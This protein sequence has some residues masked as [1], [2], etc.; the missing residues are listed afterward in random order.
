MNIENVV[1]VFDN[2][3]LK[4]DCPSEFTDGKA[5]ALLGA[6]DGPFERFPDA[7]RKRAPGPAARRRCGARVRAL[8][9][10]I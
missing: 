1:E 5:P 8:S 3:F 4:N 10:S 2:L 9:R 6:G 7:S